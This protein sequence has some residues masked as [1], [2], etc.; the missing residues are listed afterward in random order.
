M[1]SHPDRTIVL[2]PRLAGHAALKSNVTSQ[3]SIPKLNNTCL[4]QK[5]HRII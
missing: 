5:G 1:F 3:L 2:P 4:L